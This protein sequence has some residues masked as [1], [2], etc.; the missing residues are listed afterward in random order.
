MAAV[1]T[2]GL[3]NQGVGS[4]SVGVFSS[5]VTVFVSW[6]NRR[7]TRKALSNLTARE[8]EDIGLTRADIYKL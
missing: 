4:G 3:V 1:N 5:L 8:L 2:S 7:I 6:H